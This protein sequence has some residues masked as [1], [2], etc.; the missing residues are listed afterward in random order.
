MRPEVFAFN[1][2]TIMN[3]KT[4]QIITVIFT[5]IASGMATLSGIMKLIG[6]T[7]VVK[8]L[9]I[10]GV[11]PYIPVLG[12]MEIVFSALFIYPKTMKLGFIL[13]SCY[14]AGAMAADLSHDKPLANAGFVL[15]LVW[16]AAFLR[17]RTVFFP[18]APLRGGL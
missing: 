9:T 1:Q 2:I 5:V 12:I 8:M 16:I 10:A 4:K 15:V 6:S 11:G 18:T 3:T 14:F 17:D 7:E 13:L